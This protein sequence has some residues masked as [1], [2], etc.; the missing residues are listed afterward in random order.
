MQ[1]LR[2]NKGSVV[3]RNGIKYVIMEN[4]LYDYY[5]YINAGIL[6]PVNI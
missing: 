5:S 3:S 1:K 4:K 6:Q 2:K